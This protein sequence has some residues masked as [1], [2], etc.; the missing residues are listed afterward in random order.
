ML[1]LPPLRWSF[2]FILITLRRHRRIRFNLLIIF[3]EFLNSVSKFMS[4]EWNHSHEVTCHIYYIFS[5]DSF[6]ISLLGFS[7]WIWMKSKNLLKCKAKQQQTATEPNKNISR[8]KQKKLVK[9]LKS[10]DRWLMISVS[11]FLF[12]MCSV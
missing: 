7:F 9:Y 1:W 12:C 10:W 6:F 11:M 2:M 3:S 4:Q 5:I 8:I